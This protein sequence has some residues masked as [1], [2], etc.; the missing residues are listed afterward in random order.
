S[1]VELID[2]LGTADGPKALLVFGANPVV[3]A[4][5]A[6]RVA[7]RLR[8]LDLLVVADF[9]RSETAELADVVLPTAQWAEEDGTMTNLE[10]RVIRRRALR[11]PPPGVLT[12]LTVLAELA[13]RLGRPFDADPHAVFAE[14]RRASAGGPADYARVAG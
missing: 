2:R 13:A 11:E 10:G 7:R 8:A 3:S 12:D 4:P 1:A 9:F 6:S 5:R 14:L